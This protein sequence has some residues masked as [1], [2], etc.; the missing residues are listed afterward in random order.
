MAS[1]AGGKPGEETH[2]FQEK[3]DKLSNATE[4]TS[5]FEDELYSWLFFIIG[6]TLGSETA[7]SS[8]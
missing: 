1:E 5:D 2:Y 6:A 4:K 7:D 3:V 8:P